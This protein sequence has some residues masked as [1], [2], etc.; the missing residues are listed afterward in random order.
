M[1]TITASSTTDLLSA[2]KAAQSGDTILLAAGTYSNVNIRDLK[3]DGVTIASQNESDPAVLT[4][5]NVRGAEGLT[6]KGLEFFAEHAKGSDK[7]IVFGSRDIH[8]DGVNV[9]GSLDGNP[10]ND[11][12]AMTIRNS[13]NVSVKNSEFHELANAITHLDSKNIVFEGNY[14]HDLRMDAIRGGGTSDLTIV[15]NYFTDFYPI[16]GDHP[17]AIQ[18]W[19][20]NTSTSARDILISGNIITRGDG[21]PAQG[22]FVKA[23]QSGLP[24]YNLKITD[25]IVVGSLYNGIHVRGGVDVVIEGNTVAGHSGMNS[26][27]RLENINGINISNNASTDYQKDVNVI[28]KLAENN[29]KIGVPADKGE[30]LLKAWLAKHSGLS[31]ELV[32]IIGRGDGQASEPV[33]EVVPQPGSGAAEPAIPPA[34][35]PRDHPAAG[36]GGTQDGVIHSPSTITMGVNTTNADLTKSQVANVIGNDLDNHIVGNK[37]ANLL[38][39]G[40]GD[41][42]LDWG[43]GGSDTLI[44]GLGDDVY[45]VGPSTIVVEADGEGIDTIMSMYAV[46]LQANVENLVLLNS[47]GASGTGNELNNLIVGNAGANVLDGGAG[48]DTIRGGDGKDVIIGGS[49]DDVLYGDAGGD[50]FRF[51]VGSG[52]DVIMDFGGG[53]DREGID[54]MSYVKAGAKVA[55]TDVEAGTLITFDADNSVLLLGVDSSALQV[56]PTGAFIN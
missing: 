55:F 24:Y 5:L 4:D 28:G 34:E 46:K 20:T 23:E 36:G 1:A 9:H 39:G 8:F 30:A 53:G 49:G 7:F 51:N 50:Y 17:D 2:L 54:F 35:V 45:I 11:T 32:E 37:A 27:I 6:F 48:N 56:T 19:N 10:Q 13:Q 47:G 42:I 31:E 29:D 40:S 22:I 52:H 43:A 12:S 18:I 16:P 33:G 41:D 26:W 25:N 15:N 38:N 44:G 14:F 3:L 21:E